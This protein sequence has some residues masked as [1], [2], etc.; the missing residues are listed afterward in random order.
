MLG[1]M[2]LALLGLGLIEKKIIVQILV[3]GAG[4]SSSGSHHLGVGAGHGDLL[5]G[6]PLA[7]DDLL[8]PHDFWDLGLWAGWAAGGGGAGGG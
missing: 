7:C 4:G 3:I 6:K 8:W 5:K 2:V 1:L